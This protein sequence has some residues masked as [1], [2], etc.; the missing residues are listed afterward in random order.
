[1]FFRYNSIGCSNRWRTKNTLKLWSR[2]MLLARK[3]TC[4]LT[5]QLFSHRLSEKLAR[6]S[7]SIFPSLFEAWPS[8]MI[9]LPKL[10][11]DLLCFQV[12]WS[13]AWPKCDRRG[14]VHWPRVWIWVRR[15]S[16]STELQLPLWKTWEVE[17]GGLQ[18]RS[19]GGQEYVNGNFKRGTNFETEVKV[20]PRGVCDLLGSLTKNQESWTTNTI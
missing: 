19:N 20:N 7:T 14:L 8:C 9:E 11:P 1:M 5:K 13:W 16:K 12:V 18:H 10:N 2:W 3:S 6:S 4:K 15:D 17:A